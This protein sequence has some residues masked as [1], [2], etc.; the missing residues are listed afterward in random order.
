MDYYS[1]TTSDIEWRAAI[2]LCGMSTCRGSFLHYATQDDLQQVLTQNCGTLYRYASLLK[3]STSKPLTSLDQAVLERHGLLSAALG[4]SPP[5]WMKKF[6]ADNLRFVE[7]ERKALPCA[8]LRPVNGKPSAYSFAAA[9]MDA[10]CVMEQRIQS[11]ICCASMI[12]KLLSKQPEDDPRKN[13]YPV[14]AYTPGRAAE[15]V[16]EKVKTIVPL[17]RKYLLSKLMQEQDLLGKKEDRQFQKINST[18]S[19]PSKHCFEEDDGVCVGPKI[20]VDRLSEAVTQ[21][22]NIL[23]IKPKGLNSMKI[24]CMDVR[25]V[26]ISIEDFETRTAR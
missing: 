4:N 5:L 16:W 24:M 13:S 18:E 14:L 17:I 6:V 23:A 2:C 19:S 22:E 15:I 26:I 8:L 12:Q 10:R 7:Y 21:I 11:L 3:S 9:D 25:K 1:V 20:S